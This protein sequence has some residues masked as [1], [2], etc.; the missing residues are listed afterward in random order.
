MYRFVINKKYVNLLIA[1]LDGEKKIRQMCK[2]VDISY[3]HLTN[4][5]Q[6]WQEEGV[7]NRTRDQNSLDITLTEKGKRIVNALLQL[8]TAIEEEPEKE[9]Q[10]EGEAEKAKEELE[11]KAKLKKIEE[12]KE[13]ENG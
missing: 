7:V 10:K 11:E 9:E 1:M 2:K 4:V 8:K 5:L 12:E 6:Q 3:F 13:V